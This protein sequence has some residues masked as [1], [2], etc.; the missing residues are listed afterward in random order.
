[1]F[2]FLGIVIGVYT[3]FA[4]CAGSVYARHG[5]GG[6]MIVREESPRYF[7]VVIACYSALAIALVT[8][9]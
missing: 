9:F 7:W 2:M 8:I 1:M 3:A 4:A 6:R 5:P